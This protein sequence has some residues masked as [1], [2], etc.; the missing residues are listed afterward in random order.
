MHCNNVVQY[1]YLYYVVQRK[2]RNVVHVVVVGGGL[3]GVAL[4]I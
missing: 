4:H 1:M 2:T 3:V